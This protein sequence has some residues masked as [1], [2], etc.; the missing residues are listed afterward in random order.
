MPV[1][2]PRVPKVGEHVKTAGGEFEVVA[3]FEEDG[4]CN[5][6][7]YKNCVSSNNVPFDH[8]EYLDG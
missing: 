8:L 2:D 5:L 7:D 6:A 3:V 1:D 4:V